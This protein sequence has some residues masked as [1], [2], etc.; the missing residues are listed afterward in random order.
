[1]TA[2]NNKT[3]DAIPFNEKNS[4]V[5]IPVHFSTITSPLLCGRLTMI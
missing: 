3:D 4:I 5:Q 2:I 1:M